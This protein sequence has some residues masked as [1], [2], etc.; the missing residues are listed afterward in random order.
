LAT[1]VTVPQ[2]TKLG[3]IEGVQILRAVAVFLVAWLHAGQSM[4]GWRPVELPHFAAFGIDIFFVISGFIMS[5]ILLR[6]R[7]EP[8][9]RAT[10]G[11]LKRRLIRIF[12]IY[13]VFALLESVRLLHSH[14]FFLQNY[15]PSFLLLP[16]LFPRYPLV[17][18]FSWTM[19]FET[20]F[21]Y[22]LAATLLVTVKR[23]VPVSIAVFGVVV[24]LGQVVGAQS[25][26]WVV[27]SSPILLE[28]ILGSIAALAFSRFGQ[29]KRPGIALLTLG[30]A[31]SLY[32]RAYPDQGGA[33]GMSMVLSSVGAVRHVL[34]WGMAA[35]LIV[36][37]VIFWS[38]A[39]QSL[40]G[41][42]AVMLGNASYSAYLASAL[43]IEY[44]CRFLLKV[45]GQPSLA[46]EVLF[47]FLLVS[48]VFLGGWLSYR[49]VERPMIHWL[50]IGGGIDQR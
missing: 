27:V 18:G 14:S 40:P 10:W 2:A 3:Q 17:V 8:G 42:I 34:T 21:Y 20:F 30:V 7:Q 12:P 49:F 32:M 35:A 39:V 31:A 16:G 24:I 25:P 1:A 28:F 19:I 4:D 11:F 9:I 15:P 47:Q 33:A 44:A 6:A 13:W 26:T 50:R 45:G 37:G 23:A 38:P 22:V 43:V 46:K 41:R 48:A 29:Q 5:S 36:S